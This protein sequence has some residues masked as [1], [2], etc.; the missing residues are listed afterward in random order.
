MNIEKKINSLNGLGKEIH[1]IISDQDEIIHQACRQNPW[2]VPEFV[3]KALDGISY[4]LDKEKLKQWIS[5]YDLHSNSKKNI[6]IIMAGNIPLVGFH[7]LISVLLSSHRAIVKLSQNDKVIMPFLVDI[8]KSIDPEL[9]DDIAFVDSIDKV[10][11]VIA[12]G[13]DN[14][15]RYFK[16]SYKDIP[17]VI[18]KNRTSWCILNGQEQVQDLTSLSDDIFSYFGL[19]CRNISK[20][21][22]PDNYD[23]EN[24]IANFN[25]YNWIIKHTKY[26][27]NY[28]YLLSKYSLENRSF[29]NADYFTLLE[30]QDIVSPIACLYYERYRD[31]KHLE[32]I[33]E[34]NKSKI[35][36]VVSRE[37]WFAGSIPIGKAQLPEPWDYADNVDTLA[38]LT[39]L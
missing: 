23:M 21:Y 13:S 24:L 35:Q 14:T 4:M 19:G 6:G 5:R 25:N 29:I 31:V 12:T 26:N 10:D 20:I 32:L 7:D 9:G 39:S 18:R 17:S 28:R 15:A 36:C 11:A 34:L 8:L 22:I 38:F 27:N 30:S 37:A 33:L 1:Q 3:L 2:F 16:Y